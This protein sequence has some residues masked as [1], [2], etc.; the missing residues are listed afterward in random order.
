MDL[1]VM[2]H[3]T[4]AVC[5]LHTLPTTTVYT[6][7]CACVCVCVYVCIS[8]KTVAV[9][10]IMKLKE[11]GIRDEGYDKKVKTEVDIH[12]GLKHPNIVR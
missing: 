7:A 10:I 12:V 6:H 3:W 1:V 9:K 4:L 8:R 5:P 2:S 11:K